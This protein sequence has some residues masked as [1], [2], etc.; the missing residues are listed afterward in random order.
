MGDR[1]N[2][3]TVKSDDP[4]TRAIAP[5]DCADRG[6]SPRGRLA[7]L[8][9]PL[10]KFGYGVLIA[11]MYVA[12]MANDAKPTTIR[13]TPSVAKTFGTCLRQERMQCL[14]RIMALFENDT[15]LGRFTRTLTGADGGGS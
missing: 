2:R 4:N 14:A 3:T 9:S 13:A 10:T 11:P 6:D 1:R 7:A 12:L 8:H 5:S 15:D